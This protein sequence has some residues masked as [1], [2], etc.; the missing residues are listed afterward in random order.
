MRQLALVTGASSGIGLEL[1]RRFADHGF[2]VIINAEDDELAGAEVARDGFEALMAGKDRVVA[3]S[4]KNK[5]Q[6][7][8][9]KLLPE[10]ARA[11]LQAVQVRPAQDD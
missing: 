5:A 2:D 8:A 1:A 11:R 7:A 4:A 6:V 3:G 9:G 10:T